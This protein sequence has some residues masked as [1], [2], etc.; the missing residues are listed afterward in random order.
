M[1]ITSTLIFIYTNFKCIK[2]TEY[3]ELKLGY[4]YS[5]TSHYTNLENPLD[6]RQTLYIVWC[7]IFANYLSHLILLWYPNLYHTI[8]VDVHRLD[9]YAI[10]LCSVML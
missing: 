10:L 7:A 3:G 9:T 6:I 5:Y 2:Y 1:I 8:A 4:L